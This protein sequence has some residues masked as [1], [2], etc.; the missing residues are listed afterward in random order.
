[1]VV[2]ASTSWKDW[3][4]VLFS[5]PTSR[6]FSSLLDGSSTDIIP[7]LASPLQLTSRYELEDVP[8]T[9]SQRLSSDWLQDLPVLQPVT[10]LIPAWEPEPKRTVS[11]WRMTAL[12]APEVGLWF[13]RD[14]R[15]ENPQRAIRLE[16]EIEFD[17]FGQVSFLALDPGETAREWIMQILPDIR[18]VRIP[19]DQGGLSTRFCLEFVPAGR[20]P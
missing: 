1:L 3:T 14:A 16:G 9:A 8:A 20:R 6:G 17:A 15:L 7:P 10:S 4:P 18:K 5:L 19:M 2:V 11:G 13:Y 12:D